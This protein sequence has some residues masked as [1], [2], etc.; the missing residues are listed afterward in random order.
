LNQVRLPIHLFYF[1]F[2][3]SIEIIYICSTFNDTP[4]TEKA[5]IFVMKLNNIKYILIS[6]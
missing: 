3:N 4:G 6:I 1:Q 2:K 5:L